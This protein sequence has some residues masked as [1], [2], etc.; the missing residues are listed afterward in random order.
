M[1]WF[2]R[3]CGC[4][5]LEDFCKPDSVSVAFSLLH[6]ASLHT[7]QFVLTRLY[8]GAAVLMIVTVP[9]RYFYWKFTS[10]FCIIIPIH[11]LCIILVL[12]F[13]FFFLVNCNSIS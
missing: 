8:M 1:F 9:L 3:G 5:V 2:E 13:F 11:K 4:L 7:V 12:P 10:G 6:P